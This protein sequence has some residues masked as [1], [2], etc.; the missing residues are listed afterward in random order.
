MTPTV[1]LQMHKK[2]RMPRCLAILP[3]ESNK[4]V[5]PSTWEARGSLCIQS[6]HGLYTEILS[7]QDRRMRR[8]ARRRGSVSLGN[9]L[10]HCKI[11]PTFS[12][13]CQL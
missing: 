11:S 13:K 7:Q 3:K 6:Q 4:V 8:D 10:V 5:E 9:R 2:Q 12:L 1:K